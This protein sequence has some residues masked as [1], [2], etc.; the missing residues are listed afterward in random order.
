M[1]QRPLLAAVL[2]LAL[3]LIPVRTYRSDG[4]LLEAITVTDDTGS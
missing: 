1:N 4:T 2:T 3:L